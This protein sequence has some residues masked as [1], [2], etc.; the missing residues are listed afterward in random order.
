MIIHLRIAVLVGRVYAEVS[1]F[2]DWSPAASHGHI[3][4]SSRKRLGETN[5][6]VVI[7]GKR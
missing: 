7:F 6:E 4:R 3:F 1:W 2:L 5:R